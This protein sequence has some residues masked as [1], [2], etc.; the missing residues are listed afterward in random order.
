MKLASKLLYSE[1]GSPTIENI[2][3]T[4][5]IAV[6]VVGVAITLSK[7]LDGTADNSMNTIDEA[8][9]GKSASSKASCSGWLI[10]D[11]SPEVTVCT[12]NGSEVDLTAIDSC[13]G[14]TA[15]GTAQCIQ[16]HSV[17]YPEPGHEAVLRNL[18]DIVQCADWQAGDGWVCFGADGKVYGVAA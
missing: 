12:S 17:D 1:T 4:L 14:W 11:T 9:V 5:L 2:L 8:V 6:A 7:V 13:A 18:S 3:W 15:S 10:T 16:Y